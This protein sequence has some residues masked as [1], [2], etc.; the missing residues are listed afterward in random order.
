PGRYTIT[1]RKDPDVQTRHPI[2]EFEGV[3][4]EIEVLDDPAMRRERVAD[5][6]TSAQF[7]DAFSAFLG[8]AYQI[9]E[10]IDVLLAQLA[11]EDDKAP[12][13]AAR[14]LRYLE[15]PPPTLPAALSAALDVWVKRRDA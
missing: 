12:S 6:A 13:I 3:T 11:S 2:P 8:S 7:A 9:P 15:K 4:C 1:L 14:N 5:L 10:V